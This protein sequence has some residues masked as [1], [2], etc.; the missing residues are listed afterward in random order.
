MN[1]NI[2]GTE[3]TISDEIRGYLEK[4]LTHMEKFVH[5]VSAARAD[6]ELEYLPSE[7]KMYRAEVMLHEPSLKQPLRTEATGSTL[8]EA[9]DIASGE[10]TS[11]LTRSKKKRITNFRQSALRVK[12]Y[13]R[14]WRDSV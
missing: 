14:G 3:V 12:D 11:E 5:N 8:Y 2:K 7:A 9:I 10:L 13:L 6:V 4:K 1:Y